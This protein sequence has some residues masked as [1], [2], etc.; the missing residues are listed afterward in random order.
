MA[1]SNS[2]A[3]LANGVLLGSSFGS[4]GASGVIC[5]SDDTSLACTAKRFA[6]VIQTFFMLIIM[7]ALV[8]WAYFHQKKIYK[9]IRY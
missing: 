1:R 6:A 7:T 2:G 8:A 4:G 3:G 5:L 9:A